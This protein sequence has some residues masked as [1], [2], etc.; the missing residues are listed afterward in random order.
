LNSDLT[1]REL[2]VLRMVFNVD[3]NQ[4]L[5]AQK[6]GMSLTTLKTHLTRGI[7]KKLLVNNV[8]GAFRV[9]LSLRL[10]DLQASV[11]AFPPAYFLS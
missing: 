11:Q 1:K 8:G 3:G 10:L 4:Q 9:G 2:D 6:L 7:Y 5:A